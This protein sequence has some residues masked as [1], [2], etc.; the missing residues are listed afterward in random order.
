MTQK[1][2]H[3]D[4]TGHSKPRQEQRQSSDIAEAYRR[5]YADGEG[6]GKEL[7]GWEREGCNEDLCD[8]I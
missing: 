3:P 7:E 8:R 5:A 6:L 2:L 1:K 4:G